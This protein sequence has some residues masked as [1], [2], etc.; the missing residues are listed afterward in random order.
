M[1]CTCLEPHVTFEQYSHCHVCGGEVPSDDTI[2]FF[3]HHPD[4]TQESTMM[5]TD[6]NPDTQEIVYQL[7]HQDCQDMMYRNAEKIS[8]MDHN[9]TLVWYSEYFCGQDAAF[10]AW[11]RSGPVQDWNLVKMYGVGWTLV[12]LD[13]FQPMSDIDRETVVDAAM[14]AQPMY[15]PIERVVC[16]QR[17]TLKELAALL[18]NQTE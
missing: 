1:H 15:V 7:S 18:S 12:N 9:D 4:A 11:H 8:D 6:I 5:T 14:C 17:L 16:S 2:S 10:D 13:P 3:Q